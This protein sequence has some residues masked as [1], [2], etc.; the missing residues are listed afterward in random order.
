MFTYDSR[1][2][3]APDKA[4]FITVEVLPKGTRIVGLAPIGVRLRGIVVGQGRIKLERGCPPCEFTPCVAYV[5]KWV[6]IK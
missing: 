1:Q 3:P 5:G 4:P 2:F 6:N